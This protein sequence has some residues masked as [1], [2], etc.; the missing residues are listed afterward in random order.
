M[1][2]HGVTVSNVMRAMVCSCGV[3]ALDLHCTSDA[4]ITHKL[5]HRI[6]ISR[7]AHRSVW[8]FDHHRKLESHL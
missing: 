2:V 7:R 6:Q 5:D 1:I 3:P 8:C 4:H